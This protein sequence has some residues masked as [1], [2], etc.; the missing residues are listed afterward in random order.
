MLGTIYALMQQFS[1]QGCSERCRSSSLLMDQWHSLGAKQRGE[2]MGGGYTGVCRG[3]VG[4]GKEEE[5]EGGTSRQTSLCCTDA[6]FEVKP[7]SGLPTEME[8]H[9]FCRTFGPVRV[10]HPFI[11]K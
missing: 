10:N 5:E 7:L 6:K 4:T 2:H 1:Q 8:T 9:Y 3:E 11:F